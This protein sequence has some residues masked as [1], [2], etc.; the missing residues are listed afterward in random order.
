MAGIFFGQNLFADSPLTSTNFSEAYK[1][2]QIIQ[3]ASQAKGQLTIPLMDYLYDNN[4][5]IELKM[6]LIN[7]L[8][9]DFDG[10]NNSTLFF[11]YL[12]NKNKYKNIVTFLSKANGDLLISMA[13]LKAMDN[14]F[15]V[16]NAIIYA[17]KAKS[18]NTNSYTTHII[19]ALIEAQKTFENDWCE[20]YNLVN[21]VRQNQALNR[22]MK[23]DAIDI[24]FEYMNLYQEYCED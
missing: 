13:Y 24:I 20:V 7:E 6:A 14:Y 21:N 15:E 5:P 11:E 22:D 16:D 1:D 23:A 17:Q 8:G 4:N 3:L 2:E 10:R 12:Q 19:C 18:K 9:W